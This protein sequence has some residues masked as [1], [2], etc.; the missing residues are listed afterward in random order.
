MSIDDIIQKISDERYTAGRFPARLIFVR[1]FKDYLTLVDGLGRA[2]DVLLDIADFTKDD[3]IPRF[4]TLKIEMDKHMGKQILLLSLGEYMRIC[5]KRER[6]KLSAKFPEIWEALTFESST[7]KYIIPIF[8]GREI[9]DLIIPIQ[10]ERQQHFIWEADVTEASEYELSVYSPDFENVLDVDAKN[11]QD[12][13]KQWPMFFSDDSRRKFSI[14]TKLYKYAEPIHGEVQVRVFSELFDLVSSV[15]LDGE[16]LNKVDGSEEFWKFIAENVKK[17]ALFSET[18]K[19][20]FNIGHHFNPINVL[21]RFSELSDV[22]KNLLLMWYKIYPSDDYYSFAI[23]KA[24]KAKEI[25]EALRDTIFDILNP[26]DEFINQRAAAM[27]VMDIFYGQDYF[28]KL[29]KIMPLENRF[30]FLA[31]KTFEERSYAVKTVSDILR[32]GIS[33]VDVV[34]WVK[35][36][37]PDLVQYLQPDISAQDEITEYFNWYRCNKLINRPNMQTPCVIDYNRIDSRHR[38]IQQNSTDDSVHFWV[39][40]LGAEWIPF[41][42]E[43]IKTLNTDLIVEK[44]V[45]TA[46]SP[47]ETEYNRKW[48]QN[49]V[50]WDRLD[51]LS[52]TDMPDDHSYFSCIVRQLEIMNE[53]A[54]HIVELLAK[55]DRVII[56][57]DHGSS[58]L[59]A[60]SFHD[61]ENFAVEPPENAAAG[62]IHDGMTPEEYLVPVIVI[63]RKVPL[64]QKLKKPK[65]III[66]NEMGLP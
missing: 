25:P 58:R 3:T 65:G 35:N 14:C 54:L 38:L 33:T 18:I 4:N 42:A 55:T 39:D 50:K 2:C 48:R 53:I 61:A 30:L 64:F 62:E 44:D 40:G 45:A 19:H 36:I 5:L 60:L 47:T 27:R 11:L 49:D 24:L 15:V 12:W 1:N 20:I 46:L 51:K 7:T 52:H 9:F 26:S 6:N 23:N 31:C 41:L 28:Q 32:E 21:A 17:G 10:N 29:D 22:E 59:A 56:T 8:G 13:L 16:K 63:T 34:E 43:K 37:Y 57:G 66:H